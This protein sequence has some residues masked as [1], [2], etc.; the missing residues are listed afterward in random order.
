MDLNQVY[1][2]DA[3]EGL[4]QLEDNSIH[5]V[6]TSPPYFG[7]RDYQTGKWIG[8][9]L[10][11]EHSLARNK[12]RFTRG[13]LSTKQ[14][15]NKGSDADEGIWL[16]TCPKCGA[17]R[18]DKQIGLEK[19]PYEYIDKLVEIC[20]EVKRVLRPDG[21][22]WLNLGDSRA[23]YKDQGVRYQ[24]IAGKSRDEP[25]HGLASNRNGKVLQECGF[26]DK[27]IIGIPFRVA[28]TL[29]ADGW[30]LRQDI[31]WEKNNCMPESVKDRFTK[32]HEYIFLLTKNKN[33]FFEQQFEPFSPNTDTWYRRE[34][35][36]GKQYNVK[37]PYK[38]N[39][40]Y[41]TVKAQNPSDTKR[42]ILESMKTS[43][44]RNMRSVWHINTKPFKGAHFATFPEK[45]VE[46]MILAGCPE[47]GIVLDFFAGACTSAIAAQKLNRNFIMFDLNKEYCQIGKDR[48]NQLQMEL[49]I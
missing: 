14:A 11:C 6:C 22:F 1:C 24:T 36:E 4:K 46:R 43:K 48:L 12:S 32:C 13:G 31:V 34:L 45:L 25:A 33:Y 42:R 2:I 23:N 30:I 10:N 15:S 47:K 5:M 27:D 8:G 37:K 49:K 16:Q 39:T 20:R 41:A 3:L 21:T 38:G 7:L 40:P 26:K 17:K 9:N 35:R 19:T 29:Q 18:E 44:G 28:F